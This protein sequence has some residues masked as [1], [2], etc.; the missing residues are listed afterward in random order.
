M[1]NKQK[2]NKR[3]D[4]IIERL[5]PLLDRGDKSSSVETS[6]IT[7]KSTPPP[8]PPPIK[9][10]TLDEKEKQPEQQPATQTELEKTSV[11]V[12][13]AAATTT[14]Q[15]E[16]SNCST[17]T[18]SNVHDEDMTSPYS[19]NEDSTDS[20]KSRRKRKPVK[21]LRCISKEESRSNDTIEDEHKK[22]EVMYQD[23]IQYSSTKI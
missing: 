19:N 14:V 17:S 16:S 6:V 8:P 1:T 18:H 22:D 21:T 9:S 2:Q 3:M 20:A 10:A 7:E 11:I 13:P 12:Q 23:I 4:S 15:D 5:N